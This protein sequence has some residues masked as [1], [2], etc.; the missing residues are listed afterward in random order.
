MFVLLKS[1]VL[2]SGKNNSLGGL[3]DSFWSRI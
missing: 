3:I 1:F 2:L